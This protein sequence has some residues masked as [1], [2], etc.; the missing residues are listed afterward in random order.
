MGTE[1]SSYAEKAIHKAMKDK[2]NLA[3]LHGVPVSSIVWL[4]ENRYIVVKGRE[5]LRVEVPEYE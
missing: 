2:R 1:M 3:A 5:E 4:G